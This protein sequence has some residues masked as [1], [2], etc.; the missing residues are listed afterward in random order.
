MQGARLRSRFFLAEPGVP[1]GEE[2][3][4]LEAGAGRLAVRLLLLL[5]AGGV[6]CRVVSLKLRPS[7][8]NGEGCVLWTR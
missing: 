4:G 8:F 1:S 2:A 3:Y 5:P 6:R 7:A